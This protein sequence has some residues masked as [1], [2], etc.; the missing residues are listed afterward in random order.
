M[1]ENKVEVEIDE[2]HKVELTTITDE[3]KKVCMSVSIACHFFMGQ[4]ICWGHSFYVS[5]CL[6]MTCLGV[7]TGKAYSPAG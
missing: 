2:D 5:R 7:Q 6:V 4:D 3:E 1:A